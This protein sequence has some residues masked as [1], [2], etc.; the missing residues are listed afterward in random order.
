MISPSTHVDTTPI[1]IAASTIPP[2]P[3]ITPASPDYT[4]TSPDYSPASN[5]K[6]DPSEDPSPDHIPPLP[7]TLPFL[8]SIDDSLDS[9]I[10]YTTP[11]ST[12]GTPFTDTTLSTQRSPIASVALR[13]RDMILTLG[14]P[15]PYG[16]P[17][18]YHLNGPI[19]MMTVRKRVGP[20]PTYRLAVRHSVDYS[21][22]DHFSLDDS[23]RDSSSSSS[24]KTSSD[25][26]ADAL[27]DSASSCSSS[28]HSLP[29]PS[30]V[31]LARGADPLLYLSIPLSLPILEALSLEDRFGPYVSRGTD[32]DMDV[33]VVRSD[34]IEINTEIRVEID[35]C[36]AY[37]DA[38]RDR[39]I[40]ARVVVKTVDRNKVGTDVRG[41]VEV[42]VDRVTHPVTSDDIPKPAQE[43]G[44]VEVTYETLGDLVQRFDDH[45]VEIL[46]H[47]VQAIERL[48]T[49]RCGNSK[50][51]GY[52]TRDCMATVTPNTQR[53]LVGNQP[54][55]VCYECGRPGHFRKDCPKLR[56]QNRGN[57]IGNKN[58]NKTG[59]HIGGNEATVKAYAIR[60]G[61]ENLDFNVVTCTFLLND[62]YAS[63]L[64]DSGADRNFVS[65]TFS[66]L[67]NVAPSTLDTSYAIKLTD[68]RISETNVILRDFTL[69]LLG[70]SFDIDLMHVELGS[71]DV[72]IGCSKIARPMT[73]LTQK[74]V[75]FD[76]GE[77]AEAAIQSLK[78]KLCSTSILALPEGSENF[79]V[80]CDASHKGLGAVLMQKEKVI[81]YASCQLKVHEKNYTTH[82]LELGAVVFALKIWRHYLYDRLTKSAYFLPM[83]EDDTMEKLTRQYL[84]E[85]VLRNEVPVLII[86]NHD[87]RFTSHFWKSLNKAL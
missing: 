38:L 71:F 43:E 60:G 72:I 85:V 69:G 73:K 66:V 55:I 29:A 16:Q 57:Q 19:H 74:S 33:D 3:D 59:N 80:Y 21:S 51:V 87:G 9:D 15:I 68:G 31:L 8:S 35:E 70:H 76:S 42:R 50:R 27:S 6:S 78:Q 44:V 22:S 58:G 32:L 48:C 53:A 11:S 61:G 13:R 62:C 37:A 12:H 77:K 45:I 36:I 2:S 86:S 40:D 23:L 49:V 7:A 14:Q 34:G 30:S 10:P 17:Y 26:S 25:S 24:S 81:A 75:K 20:L 1:P 64:F 54:G 56:N 47:L 39:R 4:P 79:V 52:I 5:T 82:D 28:D 65:S 41:P 63:M 46:V 83:R 18:R 67:L 84:K